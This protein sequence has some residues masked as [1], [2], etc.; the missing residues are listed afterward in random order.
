MIQRA[1]ILVLLLAILPACGDGDPG[2]DALVVVQET[3]TPDPPPPCEGFAYR[4]T[5]DVATECDQGTRQ[6]DVC[7]DEPLCEAQLD[8][9]VSGIQTCDEQHSHDV[10]VDADASD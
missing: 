5:V 8:Q 9:A 4:Y 7:A 6:V 1:P 2:I 10:E 3:N